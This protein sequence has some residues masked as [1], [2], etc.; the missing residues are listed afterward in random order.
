MPGIHAFT[1]SRKQA[2]MP[3]TRAG[4]TAHF[5]KSSTVDLREK[6]HPEPGSSGSIPARRDV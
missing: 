5:R 6:K 2:W 4:M 3:A 1:F